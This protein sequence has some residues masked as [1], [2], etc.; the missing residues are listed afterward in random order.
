VKNSVTGVPPLMISASN[1]DNTISSR[2][3]FHVRHI[4][5]SAR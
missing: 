3:G 2:T 1:G 4:T 5:V